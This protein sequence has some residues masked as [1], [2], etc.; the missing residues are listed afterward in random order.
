MMNSIQ[1]MCII[2]MYNLKCV[3]NKSNSLIHLR[4]LATEILL[5]VIVHWLFEAIVFNILHC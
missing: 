1:F 3:W 2:G 5:G 4:F